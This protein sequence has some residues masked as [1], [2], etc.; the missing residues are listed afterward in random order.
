[1]SLRPLCPHCGGDY[2]HGPE[3]RGWQPGCVPAAYGR[4]ICLPVAHW[5]F[6][7]PSGSAPARQHGMPIQDRGWYRPEN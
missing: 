3:C 6:Q 1:M 2:E 4:E 5:A 7:R